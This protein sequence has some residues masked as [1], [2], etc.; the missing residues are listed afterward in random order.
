MKKNI[1]ELIASN[2]TLFSLIL[3]ITILIILLVILIIVLILVFNLKHPKKKK[4]SR[5]NKFETQILEPPYMLDEASRIS[6][7]F[8]NLKFKNE[9][10]SNNQAIIDDEKSQLF[11]RN[12]KEFEDIKHL[13]E[14]L[15]ETKKRY[16]E[17]TKKMNI[18]L[19]KQN[20]LL[21]NIT[22]LPIEEV[23]KIL[24]LNVYKQSRLELAEI[25]NTEKIKF[26]NELEMHAQ[27]QIV[28]AMEVIAEK[29]IT[30]RSLSTISIKDESLK[31]KIIGKHGRNKHLFEK[32]TG[33]DIIV[34]KTS[35]IT[36]SSAN[37]IR[38]EIA[39]NLFNAM[40][41]SKVIDP[42]KLENLYEVVKENFQQQL[43][44]DGKKVLEEDLQIFD[45]N[46]SIYPYVGRLRYRTSYG[47]NVLD[48]CIESAKYAEIIAKE[49]GINHEKAKRAAFFHDIGKSVDFNENYDHVESGLA[50]AK[51]HYLPDYICNAIESHHNKIEPDNIY[52][53]LVKVVDTLSAARPG[54]RS[55]S[56]TEF[57]KRVNRLEELCKTIEGVQDAYAVQ[58]GRILRVIIKPEI[59]SDN[60]LNLLHYEIKKLIE[61]DEITNKY[62]IKIIL[63]RE[64]RFEFLVNRK[65]D[66]LLKESDI[67][68]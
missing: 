45:I 52:A 43:F 62:Q 53:A 32:L 8:E 50:I 4:A 20:K 51:K 30:Q 11:Y 41:Q 64:K 15:I 2:P 29:M 65:V 3:T 63:I 61:N 25:Y 47:Q 10:F 24:M 14:E 33:T 27:N 37:P 17:S 38:R 40:I 22:K 55:D 16:S 44:I 54:V 57:I 60:E 68:S 6:I 19:E 39:V 13:K 12:V 58:S 21:S 67:F 1:N 7:D 66:A 35:E 42:S 26:H 23:K 9:N 49:I 36:I 31:G 59:I 56:L 34:E 28:S 18:L 48:H 46:P 5:K